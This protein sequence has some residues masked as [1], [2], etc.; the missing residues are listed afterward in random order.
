SL[1]VVAEG[2][3]DATDIA[4]QLFPDDSSI[5]HRVTS[6]GHMQRGG[7][8]SMR[9]RVLGARLGDAAVSALLH[10]RNRVMVGEE[11]LQLSHVP[12]LEACGGDTRPPDDLL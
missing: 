2:A 11:R 3:G 12:I 7:S 10:G 9:D 5:D 8:P 4:R 1:V 6:L